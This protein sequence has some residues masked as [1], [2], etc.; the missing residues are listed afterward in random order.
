M[1][2]VEVTYETFHLTSG[3][4]TYRGDYFLVL[5]GEF[6]SN[7]QT[8]GTEKTVAAPSQLLSNIPHKVAMTI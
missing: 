4:I 5:S 1:R 7:K 2:K 6:R 8:S 3:D